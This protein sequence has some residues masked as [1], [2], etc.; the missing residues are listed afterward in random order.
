MRRTYA[1]T[2]IMLGLLIG[3]AAYA[4]FDSTVVGINVA[5][6]ASVVLWMAIR[7]FENVVEKGINKAADT[8]MNK[9]ED[10]KNKH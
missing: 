5:V 2:G 1:P 6:V 10:R 9:Y 4:K 8:V 3:F 7:A